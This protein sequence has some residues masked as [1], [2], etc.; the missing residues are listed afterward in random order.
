[1]CQSCFPP[2]AAAAWLHMSA[3]L[4]ITLLFSPFHSST[5][6]ISLP[7]RGRARQRWFSAKAM[8]KSSARMPTGFSW[9]E[10]RLF[11]R[12]SNGG[13][14]FG[15]WKARRKRRATPI[16]FQGRDGIPQDWDG[17]RGGAQEAMKGSRHE[18][19]TRVQRGG[20][21]KG[22]I[23]WRGKSWAEPRR[24]EHDIGGLDAGKR[25]ET[26]VEKSS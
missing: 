4:D 8:I 16:S 26:R 17:W 24:A 22:G 20:K 19:K 12:K 10:R 23:K 14:K 5:L 2:H 21:E 25:G 6:A 7:P 15:G 18:R 3:R 9:H 11:G 13:G 1:M